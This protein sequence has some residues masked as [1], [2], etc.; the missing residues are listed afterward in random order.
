MTNSHDPFFQANNS[1][2]S[3]L[4]LFF[5]GIWWKKLSQ[6]EP[7]SLNTSIP[8]YIISF[9]YMV[10]LKRFSFILDFQFHALFPALVSIILTSSRSNIQLLYNFRQDH[11]KVDDMTLCFWNIFYSTHNTKKTMSKWE[12]K[13][14]LGRQLIF[15][16]VATFTSY[17]HTISSPF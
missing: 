8:L 17:I 16:N 11:K 15:I 10:Q 4:S 7:Y 14:D 13:H 6:I 1:L 2:T 9:N 5:F 12:W 3:K